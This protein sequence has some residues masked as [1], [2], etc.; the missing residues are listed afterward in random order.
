MSN[1]IYIARHAW[2]GSFGDPGWV[3][4]ADRELEPEGA[5][6]YARVIELLAE[7]GLAPELIATSPYIRCRQTA[8]IMAEGVPG[9]VE[10]VELD[11]LTPG[12]D[13]A[14]LVK[15]SCKHAGQS[16]A[17]VGHAPDVSTLTAALIGDSH[18]TIRF[19]KGSIA[20]VQL[21]DEVDYACGEL[22]WHVTAKSLGL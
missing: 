22:H 10:V 17:W 6:R 13:F 12:S 4:D 16:L 18:A 21:Y 14:A 20:A 9:E 1:F 11:A 7:R 3:T 2:A 19:A 15:W 8:D 5:E